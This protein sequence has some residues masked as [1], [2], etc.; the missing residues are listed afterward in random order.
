M[1]YKSVAFVFVVLLVLAKGSEAGPFLRSG[2]LK[3]FN[4]GEYQTTADSIVAWAARNSED[5]ET[6]HYFLG[7]C[8]YNLGLL[9]PDAA[10]ARDHFEKAAQAFEIAT[11]GQA[12]IPFVTENAAYKKA[13]TKFRLAE[14]KTDPRDDWEKALEG[15]RNLAESA[16]DDSLRIVSDYLR[17]ETALRMGNTARFQQ[18]TVGA[19]VPE[20]SLDLFQESI[21]SFG[22]V[23]QNTWK[24]R[25]REAAGVRA[26]DTGFEKQQSN[27]DPEGLRAW[28]GEHSYAAFKQAREGVPGPYLD[29]SDLFVRLA[30]F[31]QSRAA[32]DR[33]T[34]ATLL[35]GPEIQGFPVEAAFARSMVWSRDLAD[36][37]AFRNHEAFTVKAD[38]ILNTLSS[39]RQQLPEAAYWKGT[40]ESI[41]DRPGC[42]ESFQAFLDQTSSL[43]NDP[44]IKVLREAA[45]L[46]RFQFRFDRAVRAVNAE[47]LVSL[48]RELEAFNPESR[49]GQDRKDLLLVSIGAVL[50]P[51]HVWGAKGVQ[52]YPPAVRARRILDITRALLSGASQVIGQD[53]RRI[54]D[55]IQP[56]FKYS[57]NLE[58]ERTRFYQAVW[59]FLDAEIHAT[60]KP[61]YFRQAADWI[62]QMLSAFKSESLPEAEYI[63]ARSRL[64][65]DDYRQAKNILKRL[66]NTRGN[67]K[68]VFFLG[69]CFRME[70]NIAA[71]RR[72]YDVVMRKTENVQSGR[73]WYNAA[74][75]ADAT[76]A[77]LEGGDAGELSDVRFDA[78]QAR[79]ASGE[80]SLE[81]L[82]ESV[83]QRILRVEDGLDLF[84]R[85][86]LFKK[87]LYPSDYRTPGSRT[88]ALD[89]QPLKTNAGIHE[90]LGMVTSRLRLVVWA[91]D[92][93]A[94]EPSISL[95]GQT[96]E[97]DSTG[98][99]E[100]TY[101]LGDTVDIRVSQGAYYPYR[102]KIELEQ[103]NLITKVVFL[104]PTVGFQP[105]P[106]GAPGGPALF[107]Q[108][109]LDGNAVFVRES[110][111]DLK[112]TRLVKEFEKDVR[113]RDFALS[114]SL[115]S[116]AVG[117][118]ADGLAVRGL[119]PQPFALAMPDTASPEGV[120]VDSKGNLYVVD[121]RR[122]RVL[123]YGPDG[124]ML[125]EF[126][127]FG[128][129]L[130]SEVGKPVRFSY[131]SRIAVSEDA[132]GTEVQGQRFHRPVKVFVSDRNGVTLLDE[133]GLYL[134]TVAAASEKGAFTALAVEG[135]GNACRVSVYNRYTKGI[136]TFR[137][138]VRAT[139]P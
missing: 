57:E 63:Q 94:G 38:S 120:A 70:N 24:G 73:I 66:V 105:E 35:K 28:I 115:P 61:K 114:K 4:R 18:M 25:L 6:A 119:D 49:S 51:Q 118:R 104:D 41:L 91:P 31:V 33:V 98:S 96:I 29:Y 88:A 19:P 74:R 64:A 1:R 37:T 52:G 107:L 84:S 134:G 136:L 127:T 15:F 116:A 138:G 50:D 11:L 86:G 121:W 23:S 14:L 125:R 16:A 89:F 34:L 62:L 99:F 69:E 5:Q 55:R 72:C 108:D 67:P 46:Q 60:E 20:R 128:E 48:R 59:K 135:Y 40:L 93:R 30:L 100:N 92:N 65:A 112:G 22:R 17:A 85:Y 12:A 130:P 97:L 106:P 43:S 10:S 95:N 117:V 71:A 39:I 45:A 58:P 132:E 3:W 8:H 36:N 78:V 137:A 77:R 68:A 133:S 53:R 7:E 101:M 27:E 42:Q 2:I 123:V 90:R 47:P 56:L 32:G 54:L 126:G 102:E 111:P 76:I 79:D 75:S 139:N 87:G 103:P 110:D 124:A 13:W 81:A 9:A 44:R 83:Y 129:N 122:H 26:S 109:R 80:F 82:A 21:E 131:P 113:Y